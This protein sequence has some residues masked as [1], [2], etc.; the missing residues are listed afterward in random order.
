VNTPLDASSNLS[1]TQKHMDQMQKIKHIIP[2][3]WSYEQ[4]QQIHHWDDGMHE[5][6]IIGD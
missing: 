1:S 4:K 2:D 6:Y 5:C 3:H